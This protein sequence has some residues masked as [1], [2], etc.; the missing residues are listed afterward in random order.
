MMR[1]GVRQGCPISPLLFILALEPA[2]RRI[3]NLE[4]GYKI[5]NHRID[6]LAYADDI[7]LVSESA[8]GLQDQLNSISTWADW[9][10]FHFNIQKCATL[11]VAGKAHCTGPEHFTLNHDRI[12]NLREDES[13]RH[14]GVPTGFTKCDTEDAT[15]DSIIS[16]VSKLD[17]SK[18]AP[19][20][21]VDA[22]NTFVTPKLS[23]CFIT[24]TNPK[25][26][27]NKID[28]TVKRCVKRW[29]GLPQR[30][31]AEV[32]VLPYQQGGANVTPSSALADIAQIC[33]ATHI[34]HSRDQAIRE[35]AWKFL[36]AV[37]ES[38]IRRT[39]NINDTCKYLDGSVDG[40]FGTE[41]TDISS[42]WTR[43]R[44]ASRR[45]RK[46]LSISW[47]PGD[48]NLPVITAK[49]LPVKARDC[50]R[51]LCCLLKESY[52]HK[53]LSKPDQGKVYGVTARHAACNHFL[54][55]GHYTSFADWRFVHRARL[56]V[57]ALR[58]H[59]RFGNETKKCRRCSFFRETLSHVLCHCPSNFR[60]IT[61]RHNA[62]LERLVKA[63]QK[64]DA[65]V[66]VNQRIP[67]YKVNCRPDLVIIHEPTK[68]ATIVDVTTPFENGQPAFEAAREEKVTKYSGLV[69]H[70]RE[71]GYDT[72]ISAF[73]VG[74]LGG[75]DPQNE[76]TLQRLGIGRKYA[77]LM[78]KLMVSDSIRW[79]NDI[80]RQHLGDYNR[81]AAI[82]PAPQRQ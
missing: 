78:R 14:L 31:S 45:L 6:V 52:L 50:Q 4:K 35:I 51:T 60:M 41:P 49:E 3:Q 76:A 66:L 64:K 63:F 59:K 20:Q 74:A 79:S 61:R 34:F 44:M 11:S 38:R 40:E 24:G 65:M 68:T 19:W 37:T 55:N 9:A 25:K 70:F 26:Q 77:S 58:G 12:P 17:A 10:G 62:I 54:N 39:P 72:H 71:R 30:A 27:L 73:V 18:L 1:S 48:N 2:L 67:G 57:V 81:S 21:K 15:F 16:V 56:S 5:H 53:L 23:F 32:V 42:M 47:I 69:H 28:K 13:Y 33:H 46:K 7:A 43:L 22:L 82:A 8:Q 80:Y 29:L 36:K 75:Y